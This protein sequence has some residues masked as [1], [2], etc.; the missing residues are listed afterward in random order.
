VLCIYLDTAILHHLTQIKIYV[1]HKKEKEKA[2]AVLVQK[3]KGF[4]STEQRWALYQITVASNYL[5]NNMT[6]F[7]HAEIFRAVLCHTSIF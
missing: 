4:Y 5:E 1:L 2:R 7:G 6:G 3:W